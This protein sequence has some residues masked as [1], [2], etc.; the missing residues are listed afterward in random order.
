MRAQLLVVAALTLIW[1]ADVSV[2][3]ALAKDAKEKPPSVEVSAPPP[4]P[5]AQPPQVPPQPGDPP[6]SAK[7]PAAP[8]HAE[9]EAEKHCR[10]QKNCKPDG[11]CPACPPPG[12]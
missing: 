12:Q 4:G 6:A 9:T 10:M 5:H 2:Q 8:R 3:P 1:S 7:P 11:P